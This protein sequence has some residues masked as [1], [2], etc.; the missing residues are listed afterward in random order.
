MKSCPTSSEKW[1]QNYNEVSPIP[2]RMAFIKKSA[3][4]KCW[5]RCGE[6]GSLLRCWWEGKLTHPLQ[7]T[8]WSF[9]KKPEQPWDSVIPLLGIYPDKTILLKET[10]SP[11]VWMTECLH[12]PPGT[13]PTL[14]TDRPRS[15]TKRRG[16]EKIHAPQPHSSTIYSSQPQRPV[17]AE[18]I[19]K[20]GYFAI[21]L[22][23]KKKKEWN[24][25]ICSNRDG[26]R[27]SHTKSVQERKTNIIRISLMYG[28]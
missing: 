15:N 8:V 19:K 21:F 25:A 11:C 13:I 27:E 2:A 4:N 24:N 26:P 18:W 16:S 10:H 7:R 22:S 3:N 23:H 28:I 20:M 14:L 9:L 12:C 1:N 6:K 17:A 5:K